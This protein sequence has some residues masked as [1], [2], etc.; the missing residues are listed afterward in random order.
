MTREELDLIPDN[1][2]S[3]RISWKQAVNDLVVFIIR[4]K[5]MF[6][7]TKFDEDFISDVIINFLDRGEASLKLYDK[8]KGEFFP[9][10]FCFVTNICN[11][12]KKNRAN[13]NMI[14]T[15][16]IRESISNYDFVIDAYQ[17]INYEELEYPK[18]PFKYT[19][20]SYKDFQ[21][22]CKTDSYHIKKIAETENSNFARIVKEKLKHY[23]PNMIQ[24]MVMVLALKSSYYITEEQIE[25]ISYYFNIDLSKLHQIILEIKEKI[26]PRKKNR[27][28]LEERRNNAYFQISKIKNLMEWNDAN[29][30][31]AEYPNRVLKKKYHKNEKAVNTLNQQLL[32][33]KILI[34]PTSQLIAEVLGLSTRQVTYYQTLARKLNIDICKV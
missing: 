19:P 3:G 27:T 34:R 30:I 11:T 33:G 7:L 17:N 9:F 26:E 24:N 4:N 2:M 15:H 32:Q 23:S 5:P 22:A 12:V 29:N 31:N 6:G 25:R 8:N 10:L 20:I 16:T 14:D 13:D 28:I 1:V 18:I 21:I